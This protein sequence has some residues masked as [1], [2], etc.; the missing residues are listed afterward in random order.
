[1]NPP[2]RRARLAV[3]SPFIDKKHG[4]ER[5]VAEWIAQLS[6]RYEVHVYSQDVRDVDLSQ[7]TWHRIWKL[8][9]PHIVNF[10]WW[11]FANRVLRVWH[12]RSQELQYDLVFSPGINCL[13]ADAVSVHIVFA[14]YVS[15]VKDEISFSRNSVRAWPRLLHRRLYYRLVTA[16][17]AHVYGKR[18]ASLILIARRTAAALERFYGQRDMPPV[19]YGGLD[20]HVFNPERRLVLRENARKEL[21]LTPDRFALVVVSNDGRNK[22]LPVLVQTLSTLRELPIDLLVVTR[23]DSASYL[24]Q[25]HD[26]GL[27]GRVHFLASRDDIEF[28]YA[29]ADA[30]V[31]PSLEDT[32]AQPPAEAM[33]CGMPVIVSANNGTCEIITDG[34]DGLILA[35]PTDV[36]SLA[37]MIRHLYEDREYSARLGMS[38]NETSRQYTWERNGRELT[39]IFERLLE[40]KPRKAAGAMARES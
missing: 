11:F 32:F 28:Y 35:D 31:G 29:A 23:E 10:L 6:P 14:E 7:V 24:A 17:E 30:Y 16:L 27:D 12:A 9:G 26:A 22:G 25:V 20:H 34:K 18:V 19:V 8:P 33:A 37:V 36:A 39:A 5:R 15:R 4:T 40:Q 2:A 38:A 1:L 13:D 3:I 21:K